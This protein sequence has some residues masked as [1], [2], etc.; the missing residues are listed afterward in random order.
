MGSCTTLRESLEIQALPAGKLKNRGT[1]DLPISC[2]ARDEKQWLRQVP[3]GPR[4]SGRCLRKVGRRECLG[5]GQGNDDDDR[6]E[7]YQDRQHRVPDPSG[8]LAV[9]VDVNIGNGCTYTF[10]AGGVGSLVTWRFP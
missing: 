4:R 1:V 10:P 3:E 6:C 5:A 8:S 9:G 2:Q 7:D